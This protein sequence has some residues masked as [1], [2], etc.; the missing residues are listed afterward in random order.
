[1]RPLTAAFVAERP[2]DYS[3]V[4]TIALY[5]VKEEEHTSNMSEYNTSNVCEY[6]DTIHSSAHCSTIFALYQ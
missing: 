3:G 1:M 5:L 4:I 2:D 6:L